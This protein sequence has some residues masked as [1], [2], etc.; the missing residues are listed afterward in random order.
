LKIVELK[1]KIPNFIILPLVVLFIFS[2]YSGITKFIEKEAYIDTRNY[3]KFTTNSSDLIHEL[4]KERGY[5]SGYLASEGKSFVS[6]LKTQRKFTDIKIKLLKYFVNNINY[7]RYEFSLKKPIAELL[8]SFDEIDKYRTDIDNRIVS[9]QHMMKYYTKKIDKLYSLIVKIDTISSD[10]ELV[11]TIQPYLLL[12]KIKEKAGIERA[13]INKIFGQGSLSNVEFYKFGELVAAQN[14]YIEHFKDIASKEQESMFNTYLNKESFK[15]VKIER[16]KLYLKNEKDKIL[17]FI[18]DYIGYGGLI[19][20]F[21]NYEL[22]GEKKYEKI[23]KKQYTNL[24]KAINQ[25]KSF[26]DVNSKEIDQ[27][28]IIKEVFSQY[29]QALIKI[30]K[31]HQVEGD[32]SKLDK[33]VSI[34]DAPA[35]QALHNLSTNIYGSQHNW[36]KHA[37]NRINLFKKAEDKVA[38]DLGDFMIEHNKILLMQLVLEITIMLIVLIIIVLSLSMLRELIESKRMLNRAQKNAKSSSFEYYIEEDVVF[39]SDQH[40]SLLNVDKKDLKPTLEAFM[41]FVHPDDINIVKE[42]IKKAMSSGD[43]I[44]YE[45]RIDLLNKKEIFVKSSLEV[46]KRDKHDKP[47]IMVGTITDITSS[48]K[49]EQEIVDTQKDV[50]F[51]MGTIGETRSLETGKHV[52]RVAKYSELLYTLYGTS[53]KEVDLLKMASPMHDIGK[54]GIPDDI[55]NKPGKL[56]PN[57]WAIMQ[58]HPE[59]GYEMLKNSNRDILKLAAT[60]ALTHHERYDGDGYPKGLKAKEIPIVGRVTGLADVFDALDNAR[61]YKK[62]WPLEDTIEYIKAQRAR[63]FDPEL[64]DLFLDNIDKFLEIRDE[65]K[66]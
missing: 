32:I 8:K 10:G 60:V 43:I 37:T 1:K 12:M 64:V 48:K 15:E 13:L 25:Y 56:T 52:Q 49:L 30:T 46:I 31:F 57:E 24:I 26:K 66:D 65:Y 50:I 6:E 16:K 18:K 28:N 41:K 42:A 47:L 36:F 63:Q 39:Y 40:Y 55:L 11:A 45:H 20:N 58:T 14:I 2:I 38:K 29:M 34:E 61:C 44:I 53:K 7:E 27:L 35:I 51:T 59:I 62:A 4:Q 21:K 22:S 17:S 3:I 5:G 19:H 33:I 23:V 54:I 9:N